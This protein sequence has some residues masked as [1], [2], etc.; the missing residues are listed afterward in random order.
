VV[1]LDFS[2]LTFCDSSGLNLLLG[3][4]LEA[5]QRAVPLHLAGLPPTVLRVFQITGADVVFPI[6]DRLDQALA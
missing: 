4:R 2:A 6:H 3:A 1:A 5:E